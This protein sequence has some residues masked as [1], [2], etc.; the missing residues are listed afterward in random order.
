MTVVVSETRVFVSHPPLSKPP[1]RGPTLLPPK[2][3]VS[4]RMN[5]DF[6]QPESAATPIKMT[7]SSAPSFIMR[8]R[9]KDVSL[10]L[11]VHLLALRKFVVGGTKADASPAR[12]RR[13]TA[14][15]L[16]ILLQGKMR[17]CEKNN[18]TMN[19]AGA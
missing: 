19:D 8:L 16:T 2:M 11:I 9:V 5:V 15:V 14:A 1:P 6:P 17:F 18:V 10:A 3:L 7:L 13:L 12:A 4:R